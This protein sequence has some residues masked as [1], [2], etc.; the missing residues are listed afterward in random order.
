MSD[1][2]SISNSPPSDAALEEALRS[3]VRTIYKN[4]NLEDLT[5][6]RVRSSAENDLDLQK[7]FFKDHPSW[8]DRSKSII[9][10]E[11]VRPVAIFC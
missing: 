7:D 9:Q 2:S 4:G 8:K 10:A 6:K 11:V 3:V 1:S 5:V